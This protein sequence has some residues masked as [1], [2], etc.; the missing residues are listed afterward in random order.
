MSLAIGTRL[1]PYEIVA[2]LGA[3]GMGEVYRAKDTK[4]DRDV[5]IKVLP[6]SFAL[7]ADRVARFTREAKT[8]ASLNHPNIAQIYGIE[9]NAIVM[10]LVDGEDLS[11]YIARG[12][13]PVADALPI[14]KQIVDALVAAHDLGI[15][16]RDLK[17]A[18]VKVRADGTVKVLDFGL[19]KAMDPAGASNAD[20]MNS[21]TLTSRGT[22]M[23]MII[24]TAA[25][26][27]PEQAKGRAVD[28]RADIWAF[29]VVLFEMLAGQRAF[30]GEDV[31]DVLAAVL[32]QD[33]NWQALPADTPVKIRRVLER[34]LERDVKKRLR[35][36]GD[37]WIG[38]DDAEP[39]A[40]VALAPAVTPRASSLSRWLPLA[41]AIVIA[42]GSVTWSIMR[43]PA[44][45][46]LPV[47]R[48]MQVLKDLSLFVNASRDGTRLAYAV[49]GSPTASGIVLRMVDQ[50][51]GKVIPGT[52]GGVFPVFSPDGQWIAY[53]GITATK[54]L[55]IPV[56]GG[57]SIPL[58]D[59]TLQDGGAWGDDNTIVFSGSKGL[60]RVS[61]DGGTP[62]AV[63]ALDAAKGETAHKRPQ[64]LPGGKQLLFTVTHA[65]GVVEFAIR[66]FSATGYRVIAK[67]GNNGTYVASGHLAYVRGS[68]LFALPFD[69]KRLVVAGGEVPVVEG[70]SA[71]GP[72]DI[73]DFSVSST[74][75]LAYFADSQDPGTT[76]A[77]A[78]RSGAVKVL[79][80]Q[81][82]RVWATGRLSADGRRVVNGI[83]SPK[84]QDIWVLD[85][86]RGTPT[87]LTFDGSNDFPIFSP[88]GRQVF[89]SGV[90]D[91]KA[92]LYSVPSDA[93]GKATLV[94]ATDTRAVPTSFSPDGKTLIYHQPSAA[95]RNQLLVLPLDGKADKPHALHDASASERDAQVSPDGRWVAYNST[96]SGGPEVYVQPFPAGG[97]KTRISSNGGDRVRWSRDGRELIYWEGLPTATLMAVD[98]TATLAFHGA[99]PHALFKMVPGTTW[100]VTPD[101]NRFLIELTANQ[102]GSFLAMVTNW[103]EELRRRAPA[104]K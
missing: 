16:H 53:N 98:V 41:A 104:K 26:M 21:P 22:Q 75:L 5:A 46:P 95:G 54:I 99:E 50:F 42:I 70:I 1:G 23:G 97:A 27:S 24:G 79:P 49:A 82:R 3:G 94:L 90:V 37:A 36:I 7:D 66:D 86:E 67:G 55:K 38:L 56:T 18:N 73:A 12:A 89:Y 44:A 96:E 33:I 74:G 84:G 39:A 64:F 4:L 52:E 35:D 100:D 91:G 15:I 85:A 92:G 45:G 72:P 101:R 40:P 80:G 77:W 78:D 69:L 6:E 51:E 34:C 83:I 11:A 62:E 88:D 87:R 103:T 71:T 8:L 29:G 2:P 28:K 9:G 10:E 60:M 19:A 93:S 48:S 17:P 32:R 81:S 68:T 57:T 59:G 31:S 76:M 43:A 65:D 30:Q 14:A 25:Y 13:M 102:T 20:A 47:T 61:A 63:T 58:C